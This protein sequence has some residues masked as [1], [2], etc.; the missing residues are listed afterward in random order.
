MAQQDGTPTR[1][2]SNNSTW[3]AFLV[4]TFLVVGLLGLFASFAA[5]LPLERAL[6]RDAA[7]DAALVAAHGPNAQADITALSDR[8]ADSAAA[9]LPVGGD[10]DARIAAERA[11]MRTRLTAEA[12]EV[13][14]RL[15]WM[16]C[17]ITVLAA[18]FGVA[19]LRVSRRG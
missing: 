10:M 15:R 5:P 18:G 4:M 12:G 3:A 19:I 2:A 6:A 7:L 9:L 14:T 1:N 13:A 16:I 11:A 8:L 17:V